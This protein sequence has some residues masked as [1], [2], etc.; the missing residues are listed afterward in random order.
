MNNRRRS[1]KA[2]TFIGR[3]RRWSSPRATICGAATA[4]RAVVGIVHIV[5][6][7]AM[8][9]RAKMKRMS[10]IERSLIALLVVVLACGA[11]CRRTSAPQADAPNA[12]QYTRII[13]LSPSTTEELYGLGLF[14]H[15]VAVSDY[16]EFPP[17]AKQIG[18]A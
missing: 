5:R 7:R 2:K 9:N 1:S 11:S 15:V 8:R 6:R 18:R 3:A 12:P 4:A 17:E 14:P 13:S 10:G 16:D